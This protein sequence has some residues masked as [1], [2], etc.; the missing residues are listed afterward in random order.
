[1][2]K[3]SIRQHLLLAAQTKWKNT[4]KKIMSTKSPIT[5]RGR[6]YDIFE[7]KGK[8]F[9]EFEGQRYKGLDKDSYYVSIDNVPYKII[10]NLKEF[11]NI[12]PKKDSETEEPHFMKNPETG[13]LQL[14]C[15]IF[16]SEI[17]LSYNKEIDTIENSIFLGDFYYNGITW[18]RGEETEHPLSDINFHGVNF[19]KDCIITN[20]NFEEIPRA[21]ITFKS[22]RFGGE[23]KIRNTESFDFYKDSEKEYEKAQENKLNLE[24]LHITDCT[25]DNEAYLHIGFLAVDNFVLSNL[26]LPQNAELN[27]GD[28][29][30]KCF[31]LTNFRNVG[32]FKLYKINILKEEYDSQKSDNPRFQI[33][34]TSIGDTDFQSL[35]LS[36]FETVKMFDN[37]LSGIN[38][39]NVQWG[40]D[41]EVGQYG[42]SKKTEIAKK[43]DTYRTLKNVVQKN[44]DQ[45]QA[46][47]FYTRE[48][49]QHRLITKANNPLY[50]IDRVV[51]GFNYWTNKFGLN[52]QQP[53][54]WLLPI[55]IVFYAL[56]LLTSGI[57]PLVIGH[58]GNY[59]EFLN[60]THKTEFIGNNWNF[61]T[62]MIDFLFRIIE[63]LLIYQTIQA[64]RKYSRKL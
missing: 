31:K 13:K 62:Y 37:I 64:F 2:A 49:E 52:W 16:L 35:N 29:Y 22:C 19:E 30:F 27:I 48:M 47:F 18:N 60:P 24:K 53:L 54:L 17:E 4:L 3:V 59:F 33:D 25:A 11:K 10:K 32:K 39:T 50:S 12:E 9:T 15:Y 45:T 8:L 56:L 57:P 14:K 5:Y 23:L 6:E 46:L 61:W 51:L 20:H 38:Y 43:R 21:S 55:S 36:S 28:C 40:E 26:R 41:I 63:G 1:M 58:W 42:T 44:N 34:N 7:S